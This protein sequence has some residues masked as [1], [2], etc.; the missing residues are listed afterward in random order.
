MALPFTD[1]FTNTNGTALS[2]HDAGWVTDAGAI[3]IQSN[4]AQATSSG[5]RARWT[6]DTPN[7]DQWIEGTFST[8]N[9]DGSNASGL[10]TRFTSGDSGYLYWTNAN[11]NDLYRMDSG[12][13]TLLA[14]GS[15]ARSTGEVL[16]L[17]SEGSTHTCTI[18]GSTTNAPTATVDSTHSSAGNFGMWYSGTGTNAVWLDVT[19]DNVGGGG[20][21]VSIPVIINQLRNQGIC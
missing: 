6:T 13:A 20:P 19:M 15:G 7:A 9:S 17:T 8:D 4:A 5:A 2:T 10:N 14:S 3:Q 11:N 16:R 18:D 21:S 12:S 1:A